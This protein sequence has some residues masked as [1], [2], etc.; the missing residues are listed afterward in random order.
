MFYSHANRYLLEWEGKEDCKHN[1]TVCRCTLVATLNFEGHKDVCRIPR[2]YE[3]ELLTAKKQMVEVMKYTAKRYVMHEGQVVPLTTPIEKGRALLKFGFEYYSTPS[4]RLIR[5]PFHATNMPRPKRVEVMPNLRRVIR[6]IDQIFFER[7][8]LPLQNLEHLLDEGTQPRS[9]KATLLRRYSFEAMFYS[10][11]GGHKAVVNTMEDLPPEK[12]VKLFSEFSNDTISREGFGELR[13]LMGK[14]M[15]RIQAF[16]GTK[17]F[18]RTVPFQYDGTELLNFVSRGGSAAGIRPGVEHTVNGPHYR[19][20]YVTGGKKTDQFVHYAMKFDEFIHKLVG[21]ACIVTSYDKYE[22]FE[23]YCVMR[24][25]DEFK[26]AWPP[27]AEE[28]AK[29][30]QKCR[31][32]FIPNLLQ[33]FLSKLMMTPRQLLERGDVIRIGQKWNHGEA[34]RFSE[35]M[36]GSFPNMHWHTGDVTKL[37]K[38]IRDWLLT[39]YVKTGSYYF[40]HPDDLSAKLEKALTIILS[41]RINVKTVLHIG[42]QW[43]LTRGMMYSGGFETSHGDSWVLLFAFCLYLEYTMA[44]H[45]NRSYLIERSLLKGLIRIVVYGDDHVFC[46]PDELVD[47]LN[48]EAFGAFMTKYIGLEIRDAVSIPYFHSEV[49]YQDMIVKP[50]VVFLKIYFVMWELVEDE[51]F[52]VIYPFKPTH[53]SLIKLFCNKANLEI[54]Y[55]LQAIGQA[56]DTRGTNSTSYTLIRHFYDY[57]VRLLNRS[58]RELFEQAMEASDAVALRN[59]VGRTGI[60]LEEMKKGFPSRRMLLDLHRID[61]VKGSNKIEN[62]D[63]DFLYG[64]EED[65]YW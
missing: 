56:Y 47:I 44:T 11:F 49:N 19:K 55:P 65:P 61:R 25:K 53:D 7:I 45:P 29:L 17:H 33:Q 6:E 35:Y 42:G 9:L 12:I 28:C 48:E 13:P 40:S 10:T 24:F 2:V 50:G 22:D 59:L 63:R 1:T 41:E 26:Y 15:H 43:T 64:V 46:T 30:K 4:N 16:L 34:Q 8:R 57:Y 54:T 32:F 58:P 51:D 23:I 14:A 36:R 18:Y 21:N 20:S 38:N 3:G 37:D 62:N 52:P 60:T 39:M 31:E 5:P 27:T